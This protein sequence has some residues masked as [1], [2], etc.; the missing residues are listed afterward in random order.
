M[1]IKQVIKTILESS[2]ELGTY[3][4]SE[5]LRMAKKDGL[6]ALAVIKDEDRLCCLAILKGEPEGAV[7]VD[8]K[9]ELYGDK[10]VMLITV[11]EQFVLYEVAEDIIGALVMGCRI[12]EKTHL[13]PTT[14]ADLP[15]FGMKR[16]GMGVLTL[17]VHRHEVPENGVRVSI[18]KDGKIVG[19]DITTQDGTVSFKVMHGRYDCIIQDRNQKIS[20]FHVNF[21]EQN[22]RV[23]LDIF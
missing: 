23:N 12:Y 17:M 19:S 21:S 4:L 20:T 3:S 11:S 9:G 5:I 18:R 16:E 15:E 10:A 6:T 7:Y 13:R 8:E 1:K 2:R 22:P 14:S